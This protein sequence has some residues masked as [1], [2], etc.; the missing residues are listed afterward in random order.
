VAPRFARPRVDL[1]TAEPLPG[2]YFHLDSEL[3]GHFGHTMTEQVSRLWALSAARA[4]YPDLKVLLAV[5][6]RKDDVT[7]AERTLLSA[8][9]VDDA[10]VVALRRSPVRVERL[11][12]AT[13]MLSMPAYVHPDLVDTWTA[14]GRT[15][16]ARAPGTDSPRR[17][18]C[19]RRT[20]KRRCRNGTEVEELFRAHGF[21]V[22]FP[23][24]HP[25]T[26]QAR[27]FREAEVV[28][29]YAGSAMFNLCFAEE[30][31]PVVV[32]SSESY[33]ATNEY[34]IASAVGHPLTVV[35]C[36][37]DLPQPQNGWSKESFE[38]DYVFDLARD[39]EFLTQA[40]EA[41]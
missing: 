25:L 29:G 41:L 40:L 34:L 12:A 39:G 13:P 31:K 5:R 22:I 28:A 33:T 32:V 21:T 11:L 17:I 4:A 36:P 18:F 19:S 37:P 20:T 9:G 38:S 8:M 15:L 27:I 3:R 30:P 23:E 26:E 2:T 6:P 16:A 1:S 7:A 24:D 10:D 14:L 35:W